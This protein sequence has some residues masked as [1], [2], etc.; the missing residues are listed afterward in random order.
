MLYMLYWP[1]FHSKKTR[2]TL[3]VWCLIEHDCK[4]CES[5][6]WSQCKW[7]SCFVL[8]LIFTIC[9]I[10]S[11]FRGDKASFGL[12]RRSE[13]TS[14]R[15]CYISKLCIGTSFVSKFANVF[16]HCKHAKGT[17]C[18]CIVAC[19]DCSPASVFQS[20]TSGWHRQFVWMPFKTVVS[21]VF[22]RQLL[23]IAISSSSCLIRGTV[24]KMSFKLSKTL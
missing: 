19:L 7:N 3:H 16:V 1:K 18:L 14:A 13:R 2:Y 5:T 10:I 22:K 24:F 15:V 20:I 9:F 4:L 11:D 12:P 23:G 21:E 17:K 6:S 8:C